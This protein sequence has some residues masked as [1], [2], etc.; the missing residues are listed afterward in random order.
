MGL[1]E[2]ETITVLLSLE[3]VEVSL[4]FVSN[5]NSLYVLYEVIWSIQV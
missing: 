2:E 3:S 4:S 1:P 5:S